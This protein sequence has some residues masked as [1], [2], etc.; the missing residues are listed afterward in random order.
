MFRIGAEGV[1][2]R[3]GDS[4][5]D[6]MGFTVL[7]S[8]QFLGSGHPDFR[9]YQS[10]RLPSLLGL[11]RSDDAGKTWKSISLNGK[12]DFHGLRIAHGQVFGFDSTGEALMVSKDG[13]KS[14]ETRSKLPLI[15]FAVSPADANSVVATTGRS[16]LKSGDGGRTWQAMG[17]Q[18][19]TLV[20]WP[21]ATRMWGV[22]ARG[23][24]FVSADGGMTWQPQGSLP[25]VPEAFLDAGNSLYA[26]VQEQGIFVSRDGG[27]TWRV[28]YRDPT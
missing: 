19:M 13:G 7:G 2:E 26:A 16:T 24:V 9:D 18:A 11:I 5:Q 28:Y 4:S 20:A 3:V 25:G 10:G 17:S 15:D 8:D 21:E 12:A 22:D 27:R 14:W 6:T 1:A 23:S